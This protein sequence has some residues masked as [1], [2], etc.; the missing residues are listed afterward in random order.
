M[1][2]FDGDAA[3]LFPLPE[4]DRATNLVGLIG[5]D[6]VLVRGREALPAG[7][8]K[9]AAELIVANDG[10]TPWRSGSQ[11]PTGSDEAPAFRIASTFAA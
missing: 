1:A 2:W 9:W 11:T 10:A 8:F 7:E 4:K 6:Q 5:A 3:R